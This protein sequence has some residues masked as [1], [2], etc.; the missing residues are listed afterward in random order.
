MTNLKKINEILNLVVV[1][2]TAVVTLAEIWAKIGP[3]VKKA[4]TP[5]IDGCKKITSTSNSANVKPAVIENS[6]C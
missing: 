4:V 5:V 1:A 3:E 6:A 2:A